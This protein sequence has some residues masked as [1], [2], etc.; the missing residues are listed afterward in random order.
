MLNE[1]FCVNFVTYVFIMCHLHFLRWNIEL[2][3]QIESNSCQSQILNFNWLFHCYLQ[4]TRKQLTLL[5]WNKSATNKNFS[6]FT[7]ICLFFQKSQLPISDNSR[8]VR[9]DERNKM[10]RGRLEVDLGS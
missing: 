7:L 1:D 8:K 3:L 2:N 5:F 4:L 6:F 9:F 10:T